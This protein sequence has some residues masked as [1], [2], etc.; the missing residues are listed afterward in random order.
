M[1]RPAAPVLT[2]RSKVRSLPGQGRS[3]I[4]EKRCVSTNCFVGKLSS[5]D[6]VRYIYV[7][8]DGYPSGVGETLKQKFSTED[9]V[10]ALL[11]LGDCSSITGDAPDSYE[12][13]EAFECTIDEFLLIPA[14]KIEYFYLFKNGRW[15]GY[16]RGLKV[17]MND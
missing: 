7:H 3:R 13:S 5:D 1:R 14:A 12:D 11:E 6:T 4:S 15:T 8:Y 17:V 9:K 2:K 16:G 10:D